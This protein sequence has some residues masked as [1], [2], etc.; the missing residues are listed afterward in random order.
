MHGPMY[1]KN[2]TEI[3]SETSP[4]TENTETQP[5][6]PSILKCFCNSLVSKT[7]LFG[8]VTKCGLTELYQRL[9]KKSSLHLLL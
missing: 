4:S 5:K 7:T 8:G 1:I 9:E 2:E 3:S 6:R